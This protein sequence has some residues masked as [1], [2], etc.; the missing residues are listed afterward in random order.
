MQV[1]DLNKEIEL[2]SEYWSHSCG[3]DCCYD[4]GED[5]SVNGE[6]VYSKAGE[7]PVHAVKAVLNQ[8]GFTNVVIS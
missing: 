2:S 5:I 7:F 3:D 8:L 4:D 1:I 6:L